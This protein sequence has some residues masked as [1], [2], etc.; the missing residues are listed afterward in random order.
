[1]SYVCTYNSIYF[2]LLHW[3]I[4]SFFFSCFLNKQTK[5]PLF[6]LHGLWD[7]SS[8]TRSRTQVPCIGGV[9]S[10]SLDFQNFMR[11]ISGFLSSQDAELNHMV[12]AA[13]QA[14]HGD[15]VSLMNFPMN[16]QSIHTVHGIENTGVVCHS[17]LQWT[18]FCKNSSLWPICFGWPCMSWLIASLSY[19]SPF[20]MP[21]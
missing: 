15:S 8:L 17:F 20:T 14:L 4:N 7:L 12:I 1:M 3:H 6:W 18:T 21:L 9:E 2:M 13:N 19:A 10:L 5:K 16:E 11:N